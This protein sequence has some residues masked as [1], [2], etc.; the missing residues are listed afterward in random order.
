MTIVFPIR[1]SVLKITDLYC[2]S[3]VNFLHFSLP[4]KIPGYKHMGIRVS[5][6]SLLYNEEFGLCPEFW[7]GSMSPPGISSET[8]VSC[9]VVVDPP[10]T[11]GFM[12]L[13]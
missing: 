10:T 1:F 7:G 9:L 8:G 2:F 13:R 12:L 11:P 5:H 3:Y 4:L 6:E